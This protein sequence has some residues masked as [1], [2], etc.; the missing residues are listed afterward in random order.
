MAARD[1]LSSPGVSPSRPSASSF[2]LRVAPSAGR[3]SVR[4]QERLMGVG[5]GA[6]APCKRGEAAAPP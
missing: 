3:V 4:W 1:K 5:P 6:R 2:P